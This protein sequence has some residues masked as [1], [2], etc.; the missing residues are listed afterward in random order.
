MDKYQLLCGR[1]TSGIDSS[2]I[3]DTHVQTVFPCV[4]VDLHIDPLLTK[5]F[6]PSSTNSFSVLE[7]E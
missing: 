5:S 3:C 7:P 1:S 2:L 4:F 6:L